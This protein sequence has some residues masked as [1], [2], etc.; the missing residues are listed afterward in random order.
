MEWIYDGHFMLLTPQSTSHMQ[1]HTHACTWAHT[2]THIHTCMYKHPSHVPEK[3]G[4][5]CHTPFTKIL[6]KITYN[7]EGI[8]SRNEL[9]LAL[10][11][12]F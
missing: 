9:M 11:V 1:T 7:G 12:K 6:I 10:F 2:H 8:T 3:G 5:H 4:I